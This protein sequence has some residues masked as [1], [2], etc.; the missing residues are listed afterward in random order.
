M[1]T[2]QLA[3]RSFRLQDPAWERL[4]IVAL[5]QGFVS[6]HAYLTA[7]LTAIANG[8]IEIVPKTDNATETA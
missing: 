3:P 7:H 8:L 5:E 1:R 6:R 4:K 2:K